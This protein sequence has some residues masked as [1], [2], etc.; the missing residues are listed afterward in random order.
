MFQLLVIL[1]LTSL[2]SAR[3]QTDTESEGYDVYG[4][5]Y[6]DNYDYDYEDSYDSQVTI[7]IVISPS[8][9]LNCCVSPG[10]ADWQ[11]PGRRQLEVPTADLQYWECELHQRGERRYHLPPS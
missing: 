6:Y 5:E 10:P 1:A 8:L 7:F 3:P 2:L 11:F 9:H 4:G